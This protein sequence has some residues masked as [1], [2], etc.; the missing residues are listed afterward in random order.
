M[1]LHD[2]T[3]V[4]YDLVSP[5]KFSGDPMAE[6]LWLAGLDGNADETTGDALDWFYHVSRFGKR[7]LYCYPSGHVVV[8]KYGDEVAASEEFNRIESEFS[9]WE[10][11]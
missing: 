11:S 6:Y 8:E 4:S 3:E 10:E 1:I 9:E 2:G 5:Y 7:L